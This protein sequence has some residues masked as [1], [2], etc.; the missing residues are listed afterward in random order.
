MR[1][2]ESKIVSLDQMKAIRAQ[3]KAEGKK[4][5]FTNG[6]FDILHIGHA[7]Y[8]AFARQLGNALLVAINSDS[9]VRRLKGYPRPIVKQEDRARMLA[10]MEAV[11]YVTIFDEDTPEKLL[12]EL[13]PDFLVKGQDW[14]HNVVGREIVEQAGGKV[15]LAPLTDG[16]STSRIVEH[17]LSSYSG[18]NENK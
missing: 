12:K 13:L 11:D 4:L 17:I 2:Y 14:S 8:L 1:S 10:A 15:V 5:V 18:G 9:S 3:M 16:R 7:N 6:C